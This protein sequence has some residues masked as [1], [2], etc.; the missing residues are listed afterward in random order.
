MGF[1]DY[2]RITIDSRHANEREVTPVILSAG[3][4][5][6]RTLRYVM[7]DGQDA[8]SATGLS[9]QFLLDQDAGLWCDM[10]KVA[11]E[12]TATFEAAIPMG[13]VAAGHHKGC[14]RVID[15]GGNVINTRAF[16]VYVEKS[17]VEA[18]GDA[19]EMHAYGVLMQDLETAIAA[20]YDAAE[21]AGWYIDGHTLYLGAT[22][23]IDG[24]TIYLR[25]VEE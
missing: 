10:T 25:G 20:A 13:N 18:E 11:G 1:N 3:D 17:L 19:E 2:G 22:A 4:V 7:Y 9:A 21:K 23:A 16:A 8:M 14:V 5:T 6:G 12:D 24:T 15:S